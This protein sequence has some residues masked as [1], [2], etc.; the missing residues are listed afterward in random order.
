MANHYENE[1]EILRNK[2]KEYQ[3]RYLDICSSN[4]ELRQ[5]N[6]ELKEKVR[7]Y[8]DWNNRLMEFMD[9]TPADRETYVEEL[10]VRLEQEQ[11]F[12]SIMGML[13][14]PLIKN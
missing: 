14:F 8:E 9:M 2:S 3:Q 13:I 11:K 1:L 7:Q 4:Q 10:K 12:N 6:E 5:E